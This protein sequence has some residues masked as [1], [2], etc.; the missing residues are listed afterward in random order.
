MQKEHGLPEPVRR[1]KKR[2]LLSVGGS[3][4]AKRSRWHSRKPTHLKVR[5]GFLPEDSAY[6]VKEVSTEADLD[7]ISKKNRKCIRE[8]MT[9]PRLPQSYFVI[10]K[11][12]Q[13]SR[14]KF[15]S[16]FHSVVHLML[17]T[18]YEPCRLCAKPLHLAAT[19]RI[20]NRHE[21]IFEMMEYEFLE[22][23]RTLKRRFDFA[24]PVVEDGLRIELYAGYSE[25]VKG[26][27]LLSL[28]YH[29]VQNN[30]SIICPTQPSMLTI[31][32]HFSHVS[33]FNL[34]FDCLYLLTNAEISEMEGNGESV[35]N[36]ASSAFDLLYDVWVCC[37]L[38]QTQKYKLLFL[39]SDAWD[40]HRKGMPL[41]LTEYSKEIRND[42]DKKNLSFNARRAAIH[43]DFMGLNFVIPEN[44]LFYSD[45][46]RN[47]INA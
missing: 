17:L 16:K 24:I 42:E 45:F 18:F 30:I 3:V 20:S 40:N 5:E 25:I 46:K 31:E 26:D 47:C 19:H 22:E 38:K 15:F 8:E 39:S 9:S 23:Y 32:D 12:D 33:D 35:K 27:A 28:L 7:G 44:S 36:Y 29:V 41:I 2:K 43:Y 6:K 34:H 13:S 14:S 21:T 4:L 10:E 37:F 11:N 1:G